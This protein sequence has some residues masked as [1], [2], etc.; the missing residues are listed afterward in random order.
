MPLPD[1]CSLDRF[2]F[3]HA[4]ALVARLRQVGIDRPTLRMLTAICEELPE[5]LR[6]PIRSYHLRRVEPPLGPLISALFFGEAVPESVLVEAV[7][8]PVL[9]RAMREAGLLT[10]V[11]DAKLVC[12]LRLNLVNEDFV[13]SD[14]LAL[15]REAVMGAGA[16]TAALIQ[17]AWPSRPVGRMLDLGCGAGTVALFL[18]RMAEHAWGVDINARALTMAGLNARLADVR[19]IRFLQSDLFSA[20]PGESFDL[21]V[22][23]PPFV[24][25][26]EDDTAI[27]FLHGGARGDELT[28]RLLGDL[29]D[30]LAPGGRAVLLVELPTYDQTSV[31]DRLRAALASPRLDLLVLLGPPKDL[32]AYVTFHASVMCPEFGERFR[33]A[34]L[35][36][37]AHLERCQIRELRMAVIVV[38]KGNGAGFSR[39]IETRPLLQAE[40]TGLEIERLL[41]VQDLLVAGREALMASCLVVPCDAKFIEHDDQRVRVELPL[42]KL[43]APVVTSRSGA[44][45]LL[46]VD[47]ASTVAEAISRMLERSP[48]IR[49]AGEA[50]LLAGIRGALEAG[51]LEVRDSETT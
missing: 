8:D 21:I 20:L 44:D 47:R 27:T 25:C 14:D 35:A 19:Q 22:A 39:L 40:P 37:R 33:D 7:G 50:A 24:A 51:L 32:D 4:Q 11:R 15:G 48:R 38:R 1:L 18:A 30:R 3:E 28:L 36:Q 34:V 49:E 26:P 31:L 42:R 12:P 16:T 5:P 17:A 41:A 46:E 10:A 9:F 45:L 13:F 23:Q 43:V 2:T 29:P 6:C